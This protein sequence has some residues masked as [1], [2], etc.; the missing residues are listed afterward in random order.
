M[1]TEAA[2]MDEIP[3]LPQ[4]LSD[5]LDVLVEVVELLGL[6]SIDFASY[7]PVL[8]RLV[9]QS[10]S[11]S[12]TQERLRATEQELREHLG[13]LR[14]HNGLLE[15]W[16]KTLQEPGSSTSEESSED[17]ERRR[18]SLLRSAREYHKE[19]E[20]LI[21]QSH[22][23]KVTIT[24]LLQQQEKNRKLARDIKDKKAKIRTFQGLPPNLELARHELQKAREEQMKLI[25]LREQLLTNMAAGVA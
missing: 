14:H 23:P 19:L 15:H 5:K 13:Y 2:D 7:S 9:D 10:I 16:R 22:P 12:L 3:P 11:L 17:L 25:Q 4:D 21:A 18:E 24:A 8:S 6:D 20:A 1:S